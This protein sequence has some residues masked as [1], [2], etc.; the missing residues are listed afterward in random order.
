MQKLPLE[1]FK[2]IERVMDMKIK[3]PSNLVS[4]NRQAYE[5][6]EAK[7]MNL[8]R[9]MVSSQ[10]KDSLDSVEITEIYNEPPKM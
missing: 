4:S 9:N 6:Q 7:D 1:Q 10:I 5:L 8:T 3:E 2:N